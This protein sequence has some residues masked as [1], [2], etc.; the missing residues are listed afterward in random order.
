[1]QS[2]PKIRLGPIKKKMVPT[3]KTKKNMMTPMPKKASRHAP[4][5]FP[6]LV[7]LLFMEPDSPAK[8]KSKKSM[9]ERYR[10][11]SEIVTAP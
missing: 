8:P 10:A 1:M 2:V 5:S 4:L 11:I 9:E 7:Y 3:R 6:L